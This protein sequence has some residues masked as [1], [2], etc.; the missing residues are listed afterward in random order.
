MGGKKGQWE[1][2]VPEKGTSPIL[3]GT[4]VADV[5]D[6]KGAEKAPVKTGKV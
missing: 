2:R 1:F 5:R 6:E 4:M 3:F